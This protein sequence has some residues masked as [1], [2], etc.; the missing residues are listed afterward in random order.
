MSFESFGGVG[1]NSREYEANS[2]PDFAEQV[3]AY[4]PEM[5]VV[6]L[7]EPLPFRDSSFDVDT[8]G[9]Y[10]GAFETLIF[11]DTGETYKDNEKGV[12]NLIRFVGKKN[13]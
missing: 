2:N 5:E 4:L 3:I 10:V 9:Q 7:S 6:H 12:K 13:N 1:R 11:D 8:L